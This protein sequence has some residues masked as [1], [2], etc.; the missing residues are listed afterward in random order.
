MPRLVKGGKYAYG[1]SKVGKTGKIAIPKEAMEE[2]EFTEGEKVFIMTGSRR[3]GGFG[4]TTLGRLEKSPLSLILD[5]FPELSAFQTEKGSAIRNGEKS[6]CWTVIEKE[7]FINIPLETLNDYEVS[8]GDNLLSIRGSNLALGFAVKG[9]II[10]EAQNH[11]ELA[12][13]E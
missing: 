5:K 12:F 2:Y 1:W 3:S 6:F 11:P 13:F 9:P 4:I 10:E 8:P 7:G